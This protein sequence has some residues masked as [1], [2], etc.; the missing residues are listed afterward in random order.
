MIVNIIVGVCTVIMFGAGFLAMR[1][2]E[3]PDKTRSKTETP[4]QKDGKH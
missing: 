3:H 1:Y 2:L 4:D